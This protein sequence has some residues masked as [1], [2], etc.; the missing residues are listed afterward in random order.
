M[1][2]D[3]PAALPNALPKAR[4]LA[5][6]T[7]LQLLLVLLLAVAPGA[8]VAAA[9]TA[10]APDAAET[11]AAAATASEVVAGRPEMDEEGINNLITAI[12]RDG[13]KL[14][15]LDEMISFMHR[16]GDDDEMLNQVREAFPWSD[17]NGDE[18]LTNEE[19]WDFVQSF[20]DSSV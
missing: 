19:L 15:D 8:A 6:K 10:T 1:A 14:I 3:A 18:V 7:T 20:N 9:A 13:D 17:Q 4:W 5:A 12:D 16:D 2:P 11:D